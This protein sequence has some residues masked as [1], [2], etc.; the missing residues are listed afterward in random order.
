[1]FDPNSTVRQMLELLLS[2]DQIANISSADLFHL[3]NPSS[4][5][6]EGSDE[7]LT[8]ETSAFLLFTVANLR[9]QLSC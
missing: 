4:E 5:R 7:G 3:Q 6:L 8:L 1:M 9:F 2:R